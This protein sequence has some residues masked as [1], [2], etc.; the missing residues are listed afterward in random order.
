MQE[1]HRVIKYGKASPC[2]ELQ[3]KKAQGSRC[4]SENIFS[5]KEANRE[6]DSTKSSQLESKKPGTC[7]SKTQS[8]IELLI[9]TSEHSKAEILWTPKSISAGYSNNSC[10]DNAGLFQHMFPDSEIVKSF[11]LGPT[12]IKYLT[13]F[14]IAPYYKS[15]LLERIKESPCFVIS[16]DESLN[17]VT[18][19]CEMDLLARYFDETEERVKISIL[20]HNFSVIVLQMIL[21]RISMNY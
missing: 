19:T 18:Q 14:G 2:H 5:V 13:N 11:Q 8:F 17:P 15:V 10:S 12:K 3:W 6:R 21:K 16:Y 9:N 20:I 4:E 7:S 1:R